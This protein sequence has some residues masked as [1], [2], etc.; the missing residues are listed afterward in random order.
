MKM[1]RQYLLLL[2][3]GN[4]AMSFSMFSRPFMKVPESIE[5]FLKGFGI[6]LVF[7]AFAKMVRNKNK[8]PQVNVPDQTK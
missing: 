4:L 3:L 2:L 7:A 6:V 8:C 1:K 5:D